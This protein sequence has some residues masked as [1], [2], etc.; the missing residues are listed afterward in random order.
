MKEIR[1][2]EGYR[3]F[4]KALQ[5]GKL[6]AGMT[7]PAA[8][9]A[10]AANGFTLGHF[11]QSFEYATIG[12]FAATRS[13]GQSSSG[14]GRFDAMVVGVRLV[15][16][17]GVLQ[18]GHAP[19]SAAGPDL[20]QLVLGSEGAFGVITSVT[21]RARPAPEVRRYEAWRAD[22]FAAGLDVVRTLV[23]TDA[24]PTVLRLSDEAETAV[25][26]LGRLIAQQA[27]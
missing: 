27:T 16:P 8:E 25:A 2:N 22:S 17:V 11:P 7:G 9:E 23:Q 6:Q 12:G 26:T 4:R 14:Y 18:L 13:S 24:A 5:D 21:V 3:R 15:T 10:L 20:R 19:A 1:L